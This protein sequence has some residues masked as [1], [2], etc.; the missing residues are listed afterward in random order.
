MWAMWCR[1][2]VRDIKLRLQVT[3]GLACNAF[4][5]LG[6]AYYQRAMV[7]SADVAQHCVVL[8]LIGANRS[9]S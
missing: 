1:D 3:A 4:C 2:I 8:L 7:P 5:E 6:S 9:V